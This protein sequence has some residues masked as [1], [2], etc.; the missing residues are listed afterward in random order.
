[1]SHIKIDRTEQWE[2]TA[3]GYGCIATG[4]SETTAELNLL[5]K[6]VANVAQ[7]REALERIREAGDDALNP[8]DRDIEMSITM[9]ATIARKALKD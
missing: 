2:W 6:V 9:A 4:G 5:R 3:E 8:L 7:M 1:M